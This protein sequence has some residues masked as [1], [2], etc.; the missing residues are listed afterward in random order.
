MARCLFIVQGEGRGHM[1]Q[2]IALEEYLHEAGHEVVLVL[3]GGKQAQ[4]PVYFQEHFKER[5]SYFSSPG[6]IKSPNRKG[7]LVAASMFR[8]ALRSP[9]YLREIRRIR[10]IIQAT[11]PD[12]VFNFYELVGA[13]A[14]R[15]LD[16]SIL[17]IGLGHH[18][19]HHLHGYP[20]PQGRPLHRWL[21]NRHSRLILRGLDRVW[22]L[23]FRE[24]KGGEQIEIL[25]PL[26]RKKYRDLVYKMGDSY[27]VY[28]LSEGF[29]YDLVRLAQNDPAFRADVF[30]ASLPEI[31]CPEGIKL[32][33]PDAEKFSK[34]MSSCKGI[35]TTAGFD[36]ASEAA[37]HGIPLAVI[38]SR[39]HFEQAC[40]AL[41]IERCGVGAKLDRIDVDA[42]GQLRS[43]DQKI[44]R[45]W[46]NSKWTEVLNELED[47]IGTHKA[48]I[49]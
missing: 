6:F 13:L 46:V 20:C 34:F 37:Y 17:R 49:K 12:L 42:I 5:I 21:L 28:V 35:I 41:D 40:N 2:A 33:L 48:F 3:L 1:S 39:N 18:F 23:S 47:N 7:I 14:M 43:G 4:A 19:Y 44:Y 10:E 11:R 36:T 15:K 8:Q 29:I 27:L 24:E 16:Q 22:A 25:P 32:H 31:N 45:D 30:S 38:P 26:V 9:V